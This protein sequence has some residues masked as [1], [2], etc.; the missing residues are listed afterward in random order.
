MGCQANHLN[1][2]PAACAAHVGCEKAVQ[3]FAFVVDVILRLHRFSRVVHR[4]PSVP[5]NLPNQT[6]VY[7]LR[8]L[9][10]NLGM[11][12]QVEELK[13]H[14]KEQISQCNRL[15]LNLRMRVTFLGHFL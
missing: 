8:D 7:E 4:E 2:H 6:T 3:C 5:S 9:V 14:E 10:I 1:G 13:L 15:N 12:L 11:Q